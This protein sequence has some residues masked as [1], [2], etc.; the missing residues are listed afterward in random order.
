M[1]IEKWF[2][3]FL[4]AVV[5]FLLWR[6][7]QP[8]ALVLITAGIVAIVLAPI[9]RRINNFIKHP[10]TSAAITALGVIMLVFVPFLVVLFVMARQASELLQTSIGPD[11]WIESV[12]ALLVPIVSFLPES[13]QSY[14]LSYD[15]NLIGASVASWAFENIGALFSSTTT[16]IMQTFLFLFAVYYLIVERHHL[17]QELVELSPLRDSV[18][19]KILRG[20]ITTVRSVVF[21]VLMLAIV[22]GILAAIG[23]TIFGVPGSL[24][25]GAV[26]MLA[27]LVPFVG[28]A[29]VL[30]PA[31]L[32]LFFTGSQGSALGL[33]IWSVIVVGLAD[34]LIGPYLIKGTTH[35]HA[36]LVLLSVLGGIHAFGSIGIIIGPTILAAFLSLIEIYKSK[37]F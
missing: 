17:F 14:V 27:A 29:L 10:K 31:I 35:M 33:L 11:G 25:W 6:V 26:T 37:S 3:L 28:S 23:L 22:Q 5:L 9:D 24:I 8:F 2:F 18:D 13:M 34:N 36:F 20:I 4:V 7:I 30:V 16:L 32:F 12:R 19:I 1:T 21:G 15:L